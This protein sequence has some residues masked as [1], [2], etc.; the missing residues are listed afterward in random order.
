MLNEITCKNCNEQNNFYEMNCKK[1]GAILRSRVVNIDL[2][3]T[4]W[5]LIETPKKAF[6]NII[7]SEHKNFISFLIVFIGLKLFVNASFIFNLILPKATNEINIPVQMAISVI[8]TIL[9]IILISLLIKLV[10]SSN[11]IKTRLK[12]NIAVIIY[13]HIPVIIALI[14]LLPIEYGIFGGHWIYYNPSPFIIKASSAYLLAGVE[15]IFILWHLFL[16]SYGIY[17]Q[18]KS[19]VFSIFIAVSIDIILI[20]ATG[21]VPPFISGLL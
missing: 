1:C 20:A 14:I 12:D 16:L 7:F 3:K 17:T 5:E 15:L 8:L 21:L 9:L 18:T 4:V 10:V 13:S 11:G 2:W 6:A 19:A